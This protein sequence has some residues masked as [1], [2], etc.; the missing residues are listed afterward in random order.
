MHDLTKE[1]EVF[2]KASD[3][4]IALAVANGLVL[5]LSTWL[6]IKRYAEK[7]HIS[8]EL[9]STWI[10]RGIIPGG[11]WQQLPE[12]NNLKLVKDQV[13]KDVQASKNRK[14]SGDSRP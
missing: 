7:Y 12:L 9:V 8:T 6:T 11:C 1:F 5:D 13:Y 14:M 10:K 4:S 3:K 2:K